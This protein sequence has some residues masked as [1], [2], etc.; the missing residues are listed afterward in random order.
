[1]NSTF[2]G[3][4]IGKR[5]LIANT[6]ALATIGHNVS[7]ASTPGYNREQVVLQPFDPLYMPAMNRADTP[8]QIGQGVVVASI[9]RIHSQLLEQRIVAQGNE[10][11]YWKTMDNYLKQIGQVYQEPNGVSVRTLMDKFWSAFQDL[12]IHPSQMSSREA[13]IQRSQALVSAIH[14][15]FRSLQTI[16]NMLEQDVQ[17]N[18]GQI[19]KTM[20]DIAALDKK[21]MQVKAMGDNPNVLLDRRDVLVQRLSKWMNIT[22]NHGDPKAF[23]IFIGGME[24]VQGD[25]VHHLKLVPDTHNEGYS[26]VVWASSGESVQLQGGKLGA[27]LHLRDH[28]VKDQIQKLD[29]MTINF[30]DLVNSVHRHAYGLN[31]RTGLN[32]FEEYPFVNNV[33]GNY[34]RS[35][36]GRFDSTYLFRITGGNVLKPKQQI[37]LSGTITLNG[38]N[39]NIRIPYHST[40]TVNE[41]IKRIDNSGANVVAYLN[42][43]DQLTLKATPSKNEA[44]PSFILRHIQDSGQFLVGYAGILKASGTTGAYDWLHANEVN[45]LRTNAQAT[46]GANGPATYAVAPL[47]HPAGWIE[48]NPQLVRDPSSI[49]AGFGRNGEPAQPG[50]GSAALAIAHLRTKQVMIGKRTTFSS[51][52]SS[53]VADVGLQGQVAKQTLDSQN[54]IMK[55]LQDQ[56][57]SI[58]GVNLDEEFANMIKFQHGYEAAAKFVTVMNSMLNTLINKMGV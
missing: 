37:G 57:Q 29:N 31:G 7:N 17:T 56:K 23:N 19:N 45:Q 49:A 48:V 18:V 40:D 20:N 2:M 26:K 3:I 27:L 30:A 43:N 53:T 51:F 15:R 8:G 41:V 52:F 11:G 1:M 24:L 38:P 54:A 55:D 13:V 47:A 36:N 10:Q 42:R 14:H 44:Y 21:I 12:S 39:G 5:S 46:A 35:G 6:E 16:R 9:R 50:D 22:V 34:D 58:S 32:F 28:V 25:V 4:E 33:R